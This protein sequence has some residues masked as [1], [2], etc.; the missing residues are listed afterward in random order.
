M[1]M[2][3]LGVVTI[4]AFTAILSSA[5]MASAQMSGIYF[6]PKVGYSQLQVGSHEWIESYVSWLPINYDV[7]DKYSNGQAVLGLAVGYDFNPVYKMP[8]RA[9][10]E[11]AWRG[12]D[13]KANNL[14]D[15]GL[16]AIHET[17]EVESQSFFVNTYFDFHNSTSVTPYIGAG[18]GFARV[19]WERHRTEVGGPLSSG[20]EFS[21]ELKETNFAWNVGAGMA[22]TINDHLSLDLGYRYADFGNIKEINDTYIPDVPFMGSGGLIRV[23]QDID[24]TS[25]EVLLGLRYTL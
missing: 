21:A 14:Y 2:K 1:S 6:T 25:H 15:D 5:A 7:S 16:S 13:E 10:I 23:T 19:A 17:I 4:L 20:Q 18:L 3:K 9:E 8:I 12:K 11:Y 24:L 22:W